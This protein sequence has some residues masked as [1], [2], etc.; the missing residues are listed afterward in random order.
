METVRES[1]IIRLKSELMARAKRQAKANH[2]SFNAF[3]E[4]ALEQTVT[5]E[6]PVLPPDYKVSD[7]IRSFQCIGKDWRPSQE[8]LQSDIKL[9]RIWEKYGY[10]D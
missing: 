3:V 1:A 4:K 9:K 7:E 5:P 2:L 6:W 8:D 10:E